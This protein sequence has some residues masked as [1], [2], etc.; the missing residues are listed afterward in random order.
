MGE[1]APA[2]IL[3]FVAGDAVFFH[4]SDE[5]FEVVAH[6]IEFVNV[7]FIGGMNSDF[8]RRQTENEPAMADIHVRQLEDIAQKSAVCFGIR[9]VDNGMGTGDHSFMK[10]RLLASAATILCSEFVEHFGVGLHEANEVLGIEYSQR[11]LVC[12]GFGEAI[13]LVGAGAG[14][15]E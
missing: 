8:G 10:F 4:S 7:V 2:L 5:L 1:H 15:V 9:A 13:Q 6:E 14:G 12:V 3:D 11:T